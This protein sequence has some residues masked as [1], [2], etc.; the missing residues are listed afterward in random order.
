LTVAI[1]YTYDA[2]GSLISDGTTTYEY[3]A[4][5]R[6]IGVDGPSATADLAYNGLGQRLRRNSG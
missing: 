2:N 3:D 4:A 1:E 5:N 6:L